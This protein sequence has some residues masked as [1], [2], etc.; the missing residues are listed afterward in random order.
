MSKATK[1]SL[2]SRAFDA[3]Q[4]ARRITPAEF[5]NL[6]RI[7]TPPKGWVT[8]EAIAAAAGLAE[9]SVTKHIRSLRQMGKVEE[10]KFTIRAGKRIM[11]V[12]HYRLS[13]D[14][15]AV[16]FPNGLPE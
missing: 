10:R 4:A 3:I 7:E 2:D 1:P 8:A 9:S 13:K 14:A 5:I 6:A 12:T 16:Y 15:A 11:P